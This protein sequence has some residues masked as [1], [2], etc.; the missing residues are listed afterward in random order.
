VVLPVFLARRASF[1]RSDCDN[2]SSFLINPKRF[3]V[4]RNAPGCLIDCC[5]HLRFFMNDPQRQPNIYSKGG[6]RND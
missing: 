3:A 2:G 6:N 5:I 4:R 1:S